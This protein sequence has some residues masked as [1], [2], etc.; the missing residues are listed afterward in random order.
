MANARML[1]LVKNLVETRRVPYIPPNGK[2]MQAGETSI[3]PGAIETELYL[4]AITTI[5]DEYVHDLLH[6]RI[7]VTTEGFGSSGSQVYF[8]TTLGDGINTLFVVETGF[9]TADARIFLFDTF[10]GG[11]IYFFDAELETPGLTQV[12]FTLTP[13]PAAGQISVF[14]FPA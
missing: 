7:E 13:A 9:V 3:I 14:I 12:T 10:G 8:T 2:I 11:P 1:T 5:H 6:N 4:G